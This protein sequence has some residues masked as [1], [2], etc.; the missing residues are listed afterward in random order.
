M[1]YD[2]LQDFLRALDSA[3]ELR[4][5]KAPVDPILEVAEITDRVSK[6]A[7]REGSYP[8]SAAIG[9]DNRSSAP[10]S[11]KSPRHGTAAVNQALLFE[12]V[13]G[14]SLPLSINTFGSYKRMQMALGC[15]SFDDL[16]S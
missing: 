9:S 13:K 16:A 7:D 14:S 6:A 3:G 11:G 4:R 5:I 15:D 12:N 1:P 2:T 8:G 10:F